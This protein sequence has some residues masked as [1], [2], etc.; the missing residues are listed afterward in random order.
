MKP[1][2]RFFAFAILISAPFFANAQST[3]L[4]DLQQDFALLKRETGQLRL[5]VEQL[6]RENKVLSESLKA[7]RA[8]SSNNDSVNA[9]A[10]SLRTEMTSKDEALKKEILAQV[11][12]EMES[13]AAQTTAALKKLADAI[14]HTSPVAANVNFSENYPKDK[15]V[16]HTVV[17]GDTISGIAR[18]YGSRTK[19][20]QD[21]NKIVNPSRD[22]TLGRQ[23]F[24]PQE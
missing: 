17:S 10:I 3:S 23:I 7:T 5:E 21:A 20:I 24:V 19:W 18:K 12:T 1:M 9:L 15:G 22:L 2:K 4:A 8:A 13:L 6:R 14:G 11:K 16:I